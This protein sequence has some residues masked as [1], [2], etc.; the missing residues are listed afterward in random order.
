MKAIGRVEELRR[1]GLEN[2]ET[3]RRVY[4]ERLNLAVSARMQVET[5]AN[6]A[7]S[8]FTEEVTKWKALMVRPRERV[9]ETFRWRERFRELNGLERPAKEPPNWAMIIALMFIA[10]VFES[11]GNAYL[12]SQKNTLGILGGLIAAILVSIGNVSVSFLFGLASRYINLKGLRNLLGKLAGLL[13]IV[14]WMLFAVGYNLSVAHFRDAV[15]RIGEWAEAGPVAIQTLIA[16]PISLSNMES[17]L[18]LILGLVISVIAF[19]KGYNSHDPYPGYSKV[20]KDVNDAR[21]DYIAHLEE[22]IDAL[23]NHRDDAVETLRDANDEVHR[24]IRDSI[25]ALFGQKALQSNLGPFL[26]QCNIAANYLL[27]VYRDANKASRKE[28]APSYF[29]TAFSFEK[30]DAPE[31]DTARREEAEAQ[32]KEVS[33]MVNSAIKGIFDVFHDA[34]RA[35]YEIDEL[36]GTQIERSKVN[37]ASKLQNQPEEKGADLASED[38]EA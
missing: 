31:A 11:I 12:F 2:F 19:W 23:A 25:D 21:D 29:Q 6:D 22:S 26:E 10:I 35:H 8:R 20:A 32:I 37:I 36:E 34:V 18:L 30:F 15:E 24:N 13:F 3:N 38:G 9:Q 28:K 33:E 1:R 7:R 27:A 14:S 17:Y 5:D 4:S 16:N